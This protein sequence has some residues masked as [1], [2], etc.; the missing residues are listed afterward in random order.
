MGGDA[1]EFQAEQKRRQLRLAIGTPSPI[2]FPPLQIFEID[3]AAA[4]RQAADGD[5]TGVVG[6]ENRGQQSHRSGEVTDIVGA[7][8][9]LEGNVCAGCCR[10]DFGERLG[11]L[12]LVG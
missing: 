2:I 10:A 12:S 6:I 4:L 9:H 8:L 3:P 5:H 1:V 7:H 11:A